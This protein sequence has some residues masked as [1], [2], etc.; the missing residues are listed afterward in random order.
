MAKT[1]QSFDENR[2]LSEVSRLHAKLESCKKSCT[3][4]VKCVVNAVNFEYYLLTG[5]L[6]NLILKGQSHEIFCTRFFPQTIL[7]G[8]I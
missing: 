3:F 8:P 4:Q 6:M 5:P 1:K 7:L 2:Q